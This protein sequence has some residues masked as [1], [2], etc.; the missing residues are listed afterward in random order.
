MGLASLTKVSFQAAKPLLAEMMTC[1][2]IKP[3]PSVTRA[4]I[5]DD[6]E[7]V[8]TLL[9]L[10]K[11]VFNLHLSFFTGEKPSTSASKVVSKARA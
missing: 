3:S 10:R 6:I 7:E 9:T 8:A 11:E 1:V 5:E 4:L 2:Q